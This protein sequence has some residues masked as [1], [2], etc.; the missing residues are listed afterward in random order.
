MIRFLCLVSH[1]TFW[2]LGILGDIFFFDVCLKNEFFRS[3]FPQSAKC[4]MTTQTMGK[5]FLVK[6][7]LYNW[8]RH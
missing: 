4:K 6:T 7:Q 3:C 2:D 5:I 1:F 8:I